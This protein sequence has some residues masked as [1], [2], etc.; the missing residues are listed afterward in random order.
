MSFRKNTAFSKR[1]I[2]TMQSVSQITDEYPTKTKT[3]KVTLIFTTYDANLLGLVDKQSSHRHRTIAAQQIGS[4]DVHRSGGRGY[5]W[6][7]DR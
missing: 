4:Q 6:Q 7:V 2:L 5:C 1:H 3:G